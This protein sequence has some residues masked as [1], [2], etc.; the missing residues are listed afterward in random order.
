MPQFT[1]TYTREGGQKRTYDYRGS[2]EIDGNL[3]S[4]SADVS[5][6]GAAKGH[7]QGKISLM[8]PAQ[9]DLRG[10]AEF[11]VREAMEKLSEVEE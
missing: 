7:P 6:G 3:L 4:W 2:Y 10:H 5:C 1:G 11:L 9:Q 8:L